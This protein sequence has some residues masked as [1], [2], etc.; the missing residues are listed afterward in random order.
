MSPYSRSSVSLLAQDVGAGWVPVIAYQLAA[1]SIS[2]RA[3]SGTDGGDSD[4]A[5]SGSSP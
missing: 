4:A 3:E 2:R 1:I 5:V